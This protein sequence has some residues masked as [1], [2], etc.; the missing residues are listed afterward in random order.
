MS[1]QKIDDPDW[2]EVKIDSG[3]GMGWYFLVMGGILGI[4]IYNGVKNLDGRL[5]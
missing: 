1:D 3:P 4:A 2:G 5:K